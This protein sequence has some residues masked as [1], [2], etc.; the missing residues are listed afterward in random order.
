MR[1]ETVRSLKLPLVTPVSVF[2]PNTSIRFST[3]SSPRSRLVKGT[4]LGLSICY[5]IIQEHKGQIWVESH[6]GIGTTV[7]IRLPVISTSITE[8]SSPEQPFEIE[9]GPRQRVLVVDDEE[10][11]RHML[12]R[13]LGELGHQTTT[14][15]DVDEAMKALATQP[16]DLVIT[17]L[18]MPQKS[19]FDLSEAIRRTYPHLAERIIF[20]S[21]D[22]LSSLKPEQKEQLRGKLLSKPFSIPQLAELLRNLPYRQ[23]N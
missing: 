15:G 19:G 8:T 5:G 18:R 2:R 6:E 7:F 4:G 14:V 20:I 21:G 23:T 22:T 17:D 11:I 1:Q 13:L 12:Q 16:F 3:R 10:T 9:S